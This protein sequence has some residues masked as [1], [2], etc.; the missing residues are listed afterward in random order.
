MT[1]LYTPNNL[2][3]NWRWHSVNGVAV[4]FYDKHLLVGEIK[5]VSADGK[6]W[7]VRAHLFNNHIPFAQGTSK[8]MLLGKRSVDTLGRFESKQEAIAALIARHVQHKL[9]GN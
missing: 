2:P 1:E 5:L 8:M 9:E 4:E 6:A 3:F 7:H